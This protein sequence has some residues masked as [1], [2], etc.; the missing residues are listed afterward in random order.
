MKRRGLFLH[1]LAILLLAGITLGARAQQTQNPTQMVCTGNQDYHVDVSAIPGATYTWSLSG[2]GTIVSGNGTN[3]IIVNW[4]TPGGA[5][6]LSVFTTANGCAGPPKSVDVTVASP[7]V[8]PTLLAK[9]PPDPSVCVGIPVSATFNSGSGGVGCTDEFEYS[10]D[11]SGTWLSYTPGSPLST[12]GHTQVDIRGR[13]AGCSANL[14]CNETAWEVLASW[15]VTVAFPVTVNITASLDPVCEGVAVTYTAEVT[16]GGTAPTYSWRVNGGPVVGTSIIY[17][18][19]PVAG[20]VITCEVF[21]NANCITGNPA[22][23]TYT[24]VV[25]PLPNTSGIW[26]N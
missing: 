18:Y 20:D 1:W 7:P 11:N 26:H 19:I 3:A 9:A 14:G 5:Y 25:N 10:Y 17:T 12:T 24:P 8:G 23:G 16:N 22:T 13:R 4:T 6:T 15:T 21:S 2:G